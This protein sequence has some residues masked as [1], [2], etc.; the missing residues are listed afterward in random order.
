MA[1]IESIKEDKYTKDFLHG[2]KAHPTNPLKAW[3]ELSYIDIQQ[4]WFRSKKEEEDVE[5]ELTAKKF[6]EII[7]NTVRMAIQLMKPLR[8]WLTVHEIYN[9]KEA[10]NTKM[11]RL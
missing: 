10:E 11:S 9:P 3:E 1:D 2:M 4:A 8:R 7:A 5:D 6:F